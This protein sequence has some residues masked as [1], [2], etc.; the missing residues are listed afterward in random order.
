M[1]K[2][3]LLVAVAVMLVSSMAFGL[4]Y[5]VEAVPDTT[6]N[7]GTYTDTDELYSMIGDPVIPYYVLGDYRA[8]IYSDGAEHFIVYAFDRPA[9]VTSDIAIDMYAVVYME[10]G[11]PEPM[12]LEYTTDLVDWTV[13]DATTGGEVQVVAGVVTMGDDPVYVRVGAPVT[14]E[15]GCA[16]VGY[17]MGYEASFT[18]VPEPATMTLLLLGGIGMIRS[19]NRK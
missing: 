13:L 5:V 7:P 16:W 18:E 1:L 6:F 17:I 9:G 19:R 10:W 12:T 4:G 2:C 11:G 8:G 14:A 15:G 3:R